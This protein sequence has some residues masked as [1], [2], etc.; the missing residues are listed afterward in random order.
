MSEVYV[1][2]Y[3]HTRLFKIL[4]DFCVNTLTVKQYQQWQLLDYLYLYKR[5]VY[6]A[7]GD[8]FNQNLKDVNIK[9]SASWQVCESC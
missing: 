5:T 1:C 8:P 6:C 7:P 3:S 9:V 2:G 4:V